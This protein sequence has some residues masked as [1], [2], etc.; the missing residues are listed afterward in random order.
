MISPLALGAA[1]SAHYASFPHTQSDVDDRR[2][3]HYRFAAR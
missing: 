1:R 3:L 2:W